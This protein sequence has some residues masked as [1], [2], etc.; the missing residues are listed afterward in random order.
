MTYENFDSELIN[1]LLR[2]GRASFRTLSERLGVSVATISRHCSLLETRGVIA[3]YV[4][5]IIYE[6]LGYGLTAIIHLKV[7]GSLIPDITSRLA[8]YKQMTSI[9][10]VTGDYDLIIIAKFKNTKGMNKQIK[11][12][13]SDPIIK[14]ANTSVV[15]NAI[16]ENRQFFIE[17]LDEVE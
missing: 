13:L 10:E 11:M 12:M 8:E 7:E 16:V 9:Y 15:L 14:A 3:G 6:K 2:D 17:E 1:E 5:K 4:P